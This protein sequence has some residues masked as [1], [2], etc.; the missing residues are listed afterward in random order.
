MLKILGIHKGLP[1][2]NTLDSHVPE[3]LRRHPLLRAQTSRASTYALTTTQHR[4]IALQPLLISSLAV[5]WS[6]PFQTACL[7]C[8][9]R[10]NTAI[11]SFFS[12]DKWS[13]AR[14]QIYIYYLLHFLFLQFFFFIFSS[15]SFLGLISVFVLF[16]IWSVHM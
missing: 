4:V 3:R 10:L 13:R 2:H 9:S 12:D 14:L 7:S 5:H 6:L 1:T 8:L 16:K 15:F 11:L